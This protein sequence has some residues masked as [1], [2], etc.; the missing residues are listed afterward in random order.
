MDAPWRGQGDVIRNRVSSN[1]K[2]DRPRPSDVDSQ[3]RAEN[4]CR[5]FGHRYRT[6]GGRCRSCGKVKTLS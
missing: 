5:I 4:W 1:G 2:G 6:V 3:T